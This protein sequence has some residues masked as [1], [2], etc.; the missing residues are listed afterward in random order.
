MIQAACRKNRREWG[1][2]LLIIIVKCSFLAYIYFKADVLVPRRDAWFQTCLI[3]NA[4]RLRFNTSWK[5]PPLYIWLWSMP[6]FIW[7]IQSIDQIIWYVV[8]LS[9]FNQVLAIISYSV[10]YT[11]LT[12]PTTERV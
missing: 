8:M 12:L 4:V 3:V 5:Y 11:H 2:L 9:F 10:S 6:L 7:G 1:I